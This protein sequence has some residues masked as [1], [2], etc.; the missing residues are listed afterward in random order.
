MTRRPPPDVTKAKLEK[1][2]RLIADR[3]S[4]AVRWVE[5]IL[6]KEAKGAS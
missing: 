6:E 1:F 5:S 4:A 2:N 3:P